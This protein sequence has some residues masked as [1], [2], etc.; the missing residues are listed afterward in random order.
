MCSPSRL[1]RQCPVSDPAPRCE[2]RRQ[3]RPSSLGLGQLRVNRPLCVCG[4]GAARR[5]GAGRGGRARR[6]PQIFYTL[7]HHS[8]T[9]L[10]LTKRHTPYMYYLTADRGRRYSSRR[11]RPVGHARHPLPAC[12]DCTL[13]RHLLG[14]FSLPGLSG[15]LPLG[16]VAARLPPPPAKEKLALSAGLS[17]RKEHVRSSSTT[18][19]APAL[20]NS[21]Q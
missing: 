19:I 16:G 5:R 21:P 3:G 12:R 2:D 10:S 18:M 7:P 14:G 4:R 8:P 6:Q 13:P 15:R 17:M 1:A 11:R 20:S 9:K